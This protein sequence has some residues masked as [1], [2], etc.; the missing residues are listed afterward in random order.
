MAFREKMAATSRKDWT[1]MDV[2]L[3][4]ELCSS[5]P[6]TSGDTR[7]GEAGSEEEASRTRGSES[8][9]ALQ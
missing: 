4:H 8:V 2:P 5:S 1:G 3:Y 9:L 6:K 7:G